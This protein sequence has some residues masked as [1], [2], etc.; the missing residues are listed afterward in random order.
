MKGLFLF[1]L[2]AKG[3]F[4]QIDS[5]HQTACAFIK[6]FAPSSTPSHLLDPATLIEYVWFQLLR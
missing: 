3:L 1:G 4:C 2:M 6:P 5:F